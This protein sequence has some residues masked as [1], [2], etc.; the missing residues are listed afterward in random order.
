MDKW[1]VKGMIFAKK[2]LD[3][4][5][6]LP[7]TVKQF[8]GLVTLM[9]VIFLSFFILNNI[10]GEGDE[11]VAK[12][13]IEEKRIAQE[14]KLNELISSLPSGILVSFDGTDHFKLTDEL[15]EAVCNATK[16]IPQRAIMGANFLNYRAH[17]IYTMNGN[18]ISET[19]VK[20][21]KEKNKCFTGFIVSGKNVG[22]DETITVSGEALSF[23]STGIDTRVYF[24]KNF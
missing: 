8:G 15:Y 11:L 18:K 4:I 10:F 19:F 24:I 20:W 14:R 13:K 22:V 7:E 3:K 5:K 6:E 17:E 9:I 23:L 12:M 21:D 16:L 2:Y 1:K